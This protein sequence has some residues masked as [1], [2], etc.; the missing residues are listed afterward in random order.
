MISLAGSWM[1]MTAQAWLV[2]TL[3]GSALKLGL[4]SALQFT[5]VLLLT[6]YAGVLADRFPKRKILLLTQ[7]SLAL[8]AFALAFLTLSG[9]VR[10]WHVACLAALSGTARAFDAPA[11]QSFF[12]E[13][14]GKEDL[15]NAVALNSTI[16]NLARVVG[17]ALAGVT[18][19]ALGTGW[20]FLINGLSFFAVIYAL[21]VMTVPDRARRAGGRSALGEIREGLAYI[22]GTPAVLGVIVLL[23]AISTLALNLN[24][25]VPLL[26]REVLELDSSGYGFLMSALGAGALLGSVGL[27]TYGTE[28]RQ[29]RLIVAGAVLLGTGEVALGL[30][31]SPVLAA[32]VLFGCGAAMVTYLASSNT[33]VQTAV[34]DELRGRVMSV[35]FLVFGGVTPLG[36]FL[37]GALAERLGTPAAFGVVGSLSVM[38]ALAAAGFWRLV[39]SRG[40]TSKEAPPRQPI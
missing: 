10:F 6:L 11:R 5:P 24:V 28:G 27:A 26:A 18:I 31:G 33:S 39:P 25:L 4:V 32:V 7:V 1:Q 40:R 16:F 35:Y 29:A 12:V 23:G 21:W 13:M 36:A 2:L 19:K 15:L 17:P 38:A 20:A 9:Q 30:V 14:T 3:T 34:P 22:R 37:T 8:F